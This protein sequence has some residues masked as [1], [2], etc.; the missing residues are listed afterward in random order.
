MAPHTVGSAD[1]I[2]SASSERYDPADERWLGQVNDLCRELAENVPGFRVDAQPV[3]GTR[4]IAETLILALASTGALSALERFLRMWLGRDKT[5]RI[6][7][8][9]DGKEISLTAE[10]VDAATFRS[11]AQ[12]LAARDG[13]GP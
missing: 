5:R 9:V 8:T 12:T 2:I 7:L 4:G 11:I 6:T 13:D 3:R 1:L 10:T